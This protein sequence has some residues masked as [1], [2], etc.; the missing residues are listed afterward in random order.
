MTTLTFAVSRALARTWTEGDE[1]IVTKAEHDANFT[2]WILAAHDAGAT[3]RYVDVRPEDCTID[4]N[5]LHRYLSE[6]T[7]LV[8]LGC[9]SNATG[10][11]QPMAKVCD[12]AREVG[13]ISFLDA[14]HYAPHARI[15][16]ESIGCDLLACSAYK[17]FGPHVGLMWGR[18]DLL[19]LLTA[20]KLRPAPD[21][22]PGKWMTGTQNHEGIAG[23]AAAI[24]YLAGIGRAVAAAGLDQRKPLIAEPRS[25]WRLPR[26]FNTK[27]SSLAGYSP[28]CRNCRR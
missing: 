8:A 1:V 22:L 19:E 14:V 24:D 9:A 25:T 16:V 18:R 28:D 2:P 6:R 15:D 7:R 13:A 11:I 10:T 3:V 17:F 4:M 27:R 21:S 26:S 20:Y 23:A 12:L 5:Q